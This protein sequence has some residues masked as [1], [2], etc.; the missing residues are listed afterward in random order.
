MANPHLLPSASDSSPAN[1][2]NLPPQSP[3]DFEIAS[4]A[5]IEG[6]DLDASDEDLGLDASDDDLQPGDEQSPS[7][8][9]K[10]KKRKL[11]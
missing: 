4:L 6:L 8:Q 7:R 10:N 5:G 11:N 9:H 1:S 2:P 3:L